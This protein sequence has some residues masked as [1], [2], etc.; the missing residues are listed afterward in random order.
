MVFVFLT[1]NT[2]RYGSLTA[3]VSHSILHSRAPE[4]PVK[5]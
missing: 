3:V 5:E 1:E 4:P 2:V